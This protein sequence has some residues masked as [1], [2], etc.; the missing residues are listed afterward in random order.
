MSDVEPM[1]DM[2]E[3]PGGGE[4]TGKKPTATPDDDNATETPQIPPGKDNMKRPLDSGG[5]GDIPDS[6]ATSSPTEA[7]PSK[8]TPPQEPSLIQS[9]ASFFK[10]KRSSSQP[11]YSKGIVK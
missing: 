4:A 3:T 8:R 9:I 1:E 2:D 10:S 7:A 11:S 5:G 6:T